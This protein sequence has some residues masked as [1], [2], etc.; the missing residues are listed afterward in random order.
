MVPVFGVCF[1][2][3][4]LVFQRSSR[5]FPKLGAPDGNR[6]SAC[7]FGSSQAMFPIMLKLSPKSFGFLK[8]IRRCVGLFPPTSPLF[9]PAAKTLQ[10]FKGFFQE[11]VQDLPHMIN[12]RSLSLYVLASVFLCSAASMAQNVRPAARIVNPIDEN[13]LVALSGN[14]HPAANA[15]NDRGPV[16]PTLPMTDLI[17]VLSRSPEQQAAFGAFVTSL[18]D[19]NSPNYHQWLT[20]DQVG[21]QY[22][23]S[24]ADIATISSWLSGHGFT[25]SQVTKDRMSIRFSGTAG[26]VNQTFHTEIHNL[27]VNGAPHIA[28]MSDPQIPA[29]LAPVVIGIKSLHNFFPRPLH[30]MGQLVQHNAQTGKWVREANAAPISVRTLGTTNPTALA[31]PAA[32]AR[33]EFGISVG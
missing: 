12:S 14:T 24:T 20:P 31:T 10:D 3:A 11:R 4:G 21:A 15:K 5:A 2:N 8:R 27:V 29:A 6:V 33:P 18:S 26:M 30:H 17:L 32:S 7:I 13:Q 9:L 19:T 1:S 25:V 28:N 22:G 16:S 23:P